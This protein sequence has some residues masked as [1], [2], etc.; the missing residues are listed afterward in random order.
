MSKSIST[1]VAHGAA[2]IVGNITQLDDIKL[3]IMPS[4]L[5][6]HLRDARVAKAWSQRDLSERA[7]IPQ[8][9]ISRI[10]SGAVDPK[11]STLQDL[12]RVLDLD[13]VLLPRTALTAVDALVRENASDADRQRLREI[14]KRMYAAAETLQAMAGG[15]NDRV[16][17]AAD[18]LAKLDTAEIPSRVR[19]GVLEAAGAVDNAVKARNVRT[20]EPAV[21]ALRAVLG[22]ALALAAR[23]E[24]RPA[25]TLDDE[26]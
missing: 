20:L 21:A 15:L 22:D 7:G 2:D 6:A 18:D 14:T 26:G 23:G 17:E 24:A 5:T 9:H 13:L 3:D 11:V 10:E 1:L 4:P 25:Y 8:A 16:A 12:A 19:N